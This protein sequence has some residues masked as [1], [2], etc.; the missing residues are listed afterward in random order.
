[1]PD[2]LEVPMSRPFALFAV[3]SAVFVSSPAVAQDR[4]PVELTEAAAELQAARKAHVDARAALY[5]DDW[6]ARLSMA[7]D[8]DAEMAL[9]KDAKDAVGET[10]RARRDA[11]RE[12]R[13]VKAEHRDAPAT[14]VSRTWTLFPSSRRA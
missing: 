7:N 2:H 1:M 12:L 14:C 9:H 6:K 10:R 5:D 13:D 11:R 8:R 4:C 3:V